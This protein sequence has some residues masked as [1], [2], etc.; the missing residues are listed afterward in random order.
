MHKTFP[1]SIKALCKFKN[2]GQQISPDPDSDELHRSTPYPIKTR[3]RV[4][5][6]PLDEAENPFTHAVFTAQQLG[7][8][9]QRDWTNLV[10]KTKFNQ[11]K[12]DAAKNF[13]VAQAVIF[14]DIAKQAQLQAQVSQL[15]A[16]TTIILTNSLLTEK[17]S[18][19]AISIGVI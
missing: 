6:F 7:I 13:E 4:K 2:S 15:Q 10:D 12:D 1:W 19:F 5:T 8:Y 17:Y 16:N 3:N 18:N 9:S 14:A 11:S